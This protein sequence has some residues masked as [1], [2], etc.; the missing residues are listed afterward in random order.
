MLDEV[1]E[2]IEGHWEVLKTEELEELIESSTEGEED[3]EIEAEPA[4][5]TLPKF[6]KV[7]QIAQILKDK[8]MEYDPWMEHSIKVTHMITFAA[9]LWWV[10]KKERQLPITMSFQKFL[11]KK[12]LS[13]QRFPTIDVICSCHPAIH[14]IIV[15]WITWSRWSS[16]WPI[17]KVN[18]SLM[19]CHNTYII[20]LNHITQALYYLISP[21]EEGVSTVQ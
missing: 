4:M 15:W 21:Q 3:E 12:P 13:Y 1:E 18:G 16:F 19:L 6:A 7:F 14:I 10:R 2:H 11:A 17:Q 5:W 20:H 9:T 8:I